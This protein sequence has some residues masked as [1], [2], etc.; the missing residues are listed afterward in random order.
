MSDRYTAVTALNILDGMDHHEHWELLQQ[1][2]ESKGYGFIEFCVWVTQIA[3][4]STRLLL[5]R[6]GCGEDLI[7][8]GVYDYEVSYP[9]GQYIIT[10]VEATGSL[11]PDDVW[12][13]QLTVLI[14]EFFDQG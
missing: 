5:Q 12:Q 8:H 4:E 6:E 10:H 13:S 9:L 14:D 11:P 1:A 2:W 7:Y 3:E